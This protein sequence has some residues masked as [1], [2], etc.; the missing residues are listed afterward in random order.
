MTDL[1]VREMGR[2]LITG[3]HCFRIRQA[4]VNKAMNY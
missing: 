3:Y 1:A 4:L 2:A